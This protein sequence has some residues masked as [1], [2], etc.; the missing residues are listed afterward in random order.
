MRGLL[1]LLILCSSALGQAVPDRP[2]D[3]DKYFLSVWTSPNWK[4]NSSEATLVKWFD[5][6][7][8]LRDLKR[9]THWHHYPA[10]ALMIQRYS[11]F[12]SAADLP[13][14]TLQRADGG[15]VYKASRENIPKTAE[16]LCEAMKQAHNLDPGPAEAIQ[17]P[18]CPDGQ[19]DPSF[20]MPWNPESSVPDG[21]LF[22]V[23]RTP[24][25]NT[26]AGVA[27]VLG[28]IFILFVFSM[29]CLLTLA[30]V[31]MLTKWRI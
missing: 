3:G 4:E 11:A 8:R 26:V 24:V 25:R 12:I 9:K 10:D 30:V 27:W 18:D 16:A 6:D 29:L 15:V 31:Y 23:P 7:A 5:A 22:G 2:A 19:C 20:A 1:F 13:C 28:G 17:A 14:V 21:N